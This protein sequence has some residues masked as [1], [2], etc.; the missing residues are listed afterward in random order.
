MTV[1]NTQNKNLD[2]CRNKSSKDGLALYVHI[3][4]CETKCSY[5]DFN[6]YARIESLIPTYIEAVSKEI[7][8]WGDLLENPT[9]GS[10]FFGGGT[11]SYL[12]QNNVAR[13]LDDIRLAFNVNSEAE[14]S[15]EAN[16]GDVTNEKL[17]CYLESGIN[18][19]S[20]GIQSFNDSLLKVLSRRHSAQ[21]AVQAYNKVYDAG[22]HNI[23]IDLM[24]GIPNQKITDWEETLE[25]VRELKPTHVS[26]YCLTLEKGTPMEN[27]VKLGQIS[28]PDADIAADMYMIAEDFM[29]FMQYRHYEISNWA[30]PGNE[31][32]HNLTYWRTQSYLGIGPGA[33]SHF[34]SYR[35]YNLASPNGYIRKLNEKMP[36]L[37]VNT[38]KSLSEIVTEVPVV[39]NIESVSKRMQIA[40]TLMLELRLDTG[41]NIEEF[42]NRFDVAPEQVYG[43]TFNNLMNLG[44]LN[45]SAESIQ[46]T[47]RGRL[48]G[49]EVFSQFF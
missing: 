5:C 22:F 27:L 38:T 40:E 23:S 20:I 8:L 37:I 2:L 41:V 11:P 10:I 21:D 34:P 19:I 7:R 15:L 12:P 46:L 29:D 13:I 14:V 48:L 42:V 28:D 17:E 1:S 24:Y 47:R 39:E 44:L 32:Q 3:P 43:D 16:P 18:R 35:F 31:C 6:T 45:I 30:Q 49:N 25:N 9:V 36:D 26:M 33:H 4:F